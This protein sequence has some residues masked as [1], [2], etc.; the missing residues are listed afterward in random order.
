MEKLAPLITDLAVIMVTAG[1]VTLLFKK[2]HLP[3]VLGYIIAGFLIGPNFPWLITVADR[4]DIN[5]WADLGIIFLMFALGLEFSFKKIADM[6]AGAVVTALTVITAMV[7]VGFGIGTLLGWGRMDS[8]FL[9]GMISMSS[10]M[11]ILKSYEEYGLKEKRSSQVILGAL[12]IEDICGIFMMIILST[13]SAGQNVSGTA[14]FGEIGKLLLFLVIWLAVGILL[15]PTF[16]SKVKKLMNDET[17]IVVS[18][19]ICL[20]MVVIANKIGFSS[21][22]GAFLAG[23]IIAG[24]VSAER[25]ET[26]VTPIKNMFGAVF[27][28]SVGMMVEP[29]IL[30]EY[31]LPILVITVV[32]IFGQ[33]IF[34]TIGMVLAGEDLR[35]AVTGGTA[36]V[37]I[38]EFSFIVAA[39][40]H[41]LGV[42]SDFLYPVIICVAV[43]TIFTTP[44]FIKSSDRIYRLTKKI[45]PDRLIKFIAKNT[46]EKS[47]DCERDS[48]WKRYIKKYMSRTVICSAALFLIFF[49][50][51]DIFDNNEAAENLGFSPVSETIIVI[52]VMIVPIAVLLSGRGHI[53]MKLWLKDRKNR[54]PLMTLRILR[55]VIAVFFI[56]ITIRHFMGTSF[57]IVALPTALMFILI[58]R[59]DYVRGKSIKLEA[60]FIANVNERILQRRKKERSSAGHNTWLGEK[61][62]VAEFELQECEDGFDIKTLNSYRFFDVMI[63]KV[64]RDGKHF[65]MP[66]PEQQL[67]EGDVL[68]AISSRD[69]LEAF[70]MMMEKKKRI[71]GNKQS[72]TPLREYMYRE[73]LDHVPTENQI[74]SVAIPVEKEH[75]FAG[76]SIK[77]SGFRD[78]YKGFI[79]GIERGNLPIVDPNIITVIEEG[80]IIWA[81]GTSE[82]AEHMLEDGLLDEGAE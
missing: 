63:M 35:T 50:G 20:L 22:L 30:S 29:S 56:G 61:L 76:K 6:G 45:L 27:F 67:R 11:I 55:S 39:L 21:A 5:I 7:M 57:A 77:T 23:S 18:I 47:P 25:I 2:I 78:K 74:M 24:T 82:M 60:R 72:I 33:M 73:T 3:V 66:G 75:F 59:T 51:G 70:L 10:T 71:K 38:G 26:L 34:S 37:Q 49:M 53:F 68:Q 46:T 14:L 64:I 28:V 36:M 15:I 4:A 16:L 62:F 13:L 80:D 32:T 48:D 79:V 54:M 31:W 69:Q 40:G 52:A 19:G 41:S 12:V 65:N 8:M 81:L 9:G 43:I 1:I 58:V 44:V 42:T 17:A